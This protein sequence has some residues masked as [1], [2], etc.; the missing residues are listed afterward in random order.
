MT[1]EAM[2][3]GAGIGGLAATV[4]LRRAGLTAT[5]YERHAGPPPGPLGGTGLTL[6]SNATRALD[7]L[8]L[9]DRVAAVGVPLETFD[10]RTSTGRLLARWPVGDMGR[11]A[12]YPSLNVTRADLH[13]VL[14]AAAAGHVV[15]GAEL[16]DVRADRRVTA[17]F[18]DGATRDADLLVGADGLRS[19]VRAQVLLGSPA[20]FA[21]YA[22]YRA[23]V[24]GAVPEAPPGLFVQLW[25]RGARFG[26]YQVG[27]GRT[28]WFAVLN[29]AADERD[30]PAVRGGLL[31]QRFTGWAEPVGTLLALTRDQAREISRARVF[32]R[33]PERVWGIGPVTLLGDAI[34]PMTFNIGQGACQAIEDA[35]ALAAGVRS[36]GHLPAALRRYEEARMR[37][38]A[39]MVRRARRIGRWARWESPLLCAARDLALRPL[40]AGPAQRQH[41]RVLTGEAAAAL[42]GR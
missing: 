23:V 29:C 37:P 21:G 20:R 24:D 27:G 16:V 12:G 3:C 38:T 32:D 40:L 34:H 26:Y 7:H 10:N 36:G 31:R 1:T 19:R 42:A 30:D 5:A 25:G 14:R 15:D 33:Q 11:Q 13:R 35:V 8:G 39:Q 28:Y 18:A 41:R 9:L 6:W 4:A 17:R 22:V 2:V